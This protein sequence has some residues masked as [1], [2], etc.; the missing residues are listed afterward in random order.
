MHTVPDEEDV[1]QRWGLGDVR[2]VEPA[3]EKRDGDDRMLVWRIA[4]LLV[5][6]IEGNLI[7]MW[8]AMMATQP[9]ESASNGAA[10]IGGWGWVAGSGWI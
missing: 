7:E 10:M 8:I 3:G 2:V 9:M 4:G 6:G 5:N 1:T